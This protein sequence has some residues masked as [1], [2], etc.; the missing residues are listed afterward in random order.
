M[1]LCSVIASRTVRKKNLFHKLIRV[2]RIF[3][4]KTFMVQCHPQNIFNIQLFPNYGMYIYT[5][6]DKIIQKHKYKEYCSN[7][8]L[9][10]NTVLSYKKGST[11]T[12]SHTVNWWLLNTTIDSC[13]MGVYKVRLVAGLWCILPQQTGQ[14]RVTLYIYNKLMITHTHQLYY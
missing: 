14:Q 10:H 13:T 5:Y 12:F 8:L 6:I 3:V 2:I 7:P 9:R 11:D 1:C 4:R